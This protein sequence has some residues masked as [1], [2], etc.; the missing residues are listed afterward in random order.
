MV[1]QKRMAPKMT[2]VFDLDYDRKYYNY[3]NALLG[4]SGVLIKM[5]MCGCSYANANQCPM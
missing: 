3:L 2:D 5:R 1:Q 4:A